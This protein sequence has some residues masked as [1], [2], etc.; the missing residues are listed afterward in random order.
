MTEDDG[1]LADANSRLPTVL[2]T[3]ATTG[4]GLEF[5]RQYAEIG[6]RVIGTHRGKMPSSGLAALST[7]FSAVTTKRMDVTDLHQITTL[8]EHL[9][10][11]PLDIL[12]T[13]AGITH[14]GDARAERQN[15]G[16]F[17]FALWEAIFAT[18]VRGSLAVSQAFLPHLERGSG[19][20]LVAITSS[21]GS[22][23]D[24]PPTMEDVQGTFYCSS[25][26]ALNRQMQVLARILGPRGI[27]VLVI[28]PGA[29]STERHEEHVRDHGE[30][31]PAHMF[32]TREE[33]VGGMIEAIAQAG[34]PGDARF[35]DHDGQVHRW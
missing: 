34:P 2:V 10:G 30:I 21:H 4:I 17:D 6:W 32:L 22:L 9:R 5:A 14:D 28:N 26:A 3:G 31:W 12:I 19:R 11:V 13:N 33:S 16:S 20:K 27:A 8:A 18:N 23:T 35:V 29:V 1:K 25:K 15:L 24:P 7:Q